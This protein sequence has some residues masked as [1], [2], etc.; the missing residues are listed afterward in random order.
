MSTDQDDV[1]TKQNIKEVLTRI[2]KNLIEMPDSLYED[3][4]EKKEEEENN[5]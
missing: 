4:L 5:G 1:I 3:S 2:H